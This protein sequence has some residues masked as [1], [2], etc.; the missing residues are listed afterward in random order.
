M[1]GDQAEVTTEKEVILQTR[2]Y[3]SLMAA[4]LDADQLETRQRLVSLFHKL[5][6]KL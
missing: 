4:D 3:Q 5:V 1:D 6:E 2:F